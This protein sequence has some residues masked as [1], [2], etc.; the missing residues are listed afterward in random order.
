VSTGVNLAILEDKWPSLDTDVESNKRLGLLLSIATEHLSAFIRLQCWLLIR[1]EEQRAYAQGIS[2]M[3]QF[4][5]ISFINFA[6][7]SLFDQ[8]VPK[9]VK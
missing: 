9:L 1:N 2:K 5:R 8:E 4:S 6:S 3:I 7:I